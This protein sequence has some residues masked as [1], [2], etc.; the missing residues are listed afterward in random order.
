[1]IRDS[2]L[3]I[4]EYPH[5]RFNPLTEE[6][7]L[8][9]PGR[10]ERPWQ[11][12]VEKPTAARLPSYDPD[13]YLCPGNKRAGSARNPD[14]ESTFVFDNDFAALHLHDPQGRIDEN[15]LFIAHAEVGVCRVVCF[16]PRHD[17]TLPQMQKNAI[18]LVVDAWAEEVQS[19]G[20]RDGIN[21]VQIFENKGTVMGCSNPHPHGQIWAT[22][23]VPNIPAVKMRSQQAYFSSHGQDLLGDYLRLEM[24]KQERLICHNEHWVALV[25]FW[26]VWPY[27]AMLIPVRFVSDLPSLRPD[28]RNGLADIIKRL[29]VRY[30]NLFQTSFPYSMGWH[31]CPTDGESHPYWR[32]HAVYYP[33]L[34]RSATVRKFMV[35]YEM[36]AEPQRDITPEQAAAHLRQMHGGSD[37]RNVFK[38]NGIS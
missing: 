35:G 12:Q 1:V 34:L 31:A 18:R 27:E 20:S 17:L 22:R 32:L 24:A 11:G 19:L 37:R 16:S 33:P 7:V 21:Y 2:K 9:S 3:S 30:D 5:R 29:T 25:P 13:C 14:Y 23:H 4:A 8:C 15:D 28:E 26:A 10:T 38:S 6:W 36:T